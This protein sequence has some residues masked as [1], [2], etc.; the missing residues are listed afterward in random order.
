MSS[1]W[2]LY[3]DVNAPITDGNQ[4]IGII[5]IAR[6]MCG[7]G[8]AS[9]QLHWDMIWTDLFQQTVEALSTHLGLSV[10]QI[11]AT[12]VDELVEKI[13]SNNAGGVVVVAGHSNTVPQ[14]IEALSGE[15]VDLIPESEYDNLFVVTVFRLGRA[16]VV[17]LKYGDP[18]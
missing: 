4:N 11:S 6:R 2:A 3:K 16:K 14:I 8:I 18:S 10:I 1:I 13:V 15:S 5:N 17:N 12:N 9:P 7:Y